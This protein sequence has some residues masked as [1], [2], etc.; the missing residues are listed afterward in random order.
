MNT[1]TARL[2]TLG[3]RANAAQFAP[4]VAVNAL[5]GGMIGQQT[6]LPLLAKSEFALAGY[7]FVFAYVAAFGLTKAASN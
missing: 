6:V 4:L 3:L 7:T 5:V 1:T 2:P